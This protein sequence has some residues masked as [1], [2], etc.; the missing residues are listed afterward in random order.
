MLI[1]AQYEGTKY[2][3]KMRVSTSYLNPS[4]G[5]CL[6]VLNL[7]ARNRDPTLATSAIR[8]LSSRRSFLLPHHYEALLTAYISSDDIKT[9]MRILTIM[10]KAGLEPNSSTTRPIYMHLSKSASLPAKAWD[11]LQELHEDGHQMP[12]AAANVVIESSVSLGLSSEAIEQ[13]K[14]L[15]T[16]CGSPNTETF[17]VILQGAARWDGSKDIAMFLASEMLAAGVKP[18]SL[19]YDRLIL[20]CLGEED[21]EDAFRYLEEMVGAGGSGRSAEGD[22]DSRG[23]G[24]WMR[25]GTAAALVRRCVEA[26]DARAW[27]I[28]TQMEDR[29]LGNAKL[30]R[31]VE[32][33]WEMPQSGRKEE[34]P[35][36]GRWGTL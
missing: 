33:N 21:Y 24:W 10:A 16:I 4:D 12:A 5:I 20:I 25:G 19:T 1:V 29:G 28:L 35:L 9:A 23:K 11:I 6:S 8:V 27:D 13:Y 2:I 30:R 15:H 7:S 31:W 26:G 22:K 34:K 36:M 18:D 3:W 17:N 14:S 32:E